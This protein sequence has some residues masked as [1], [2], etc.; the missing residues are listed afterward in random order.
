[1]VLGDKAG[2]TIFTKGNG[3]GACHGAYICTLL[4][5][6]Y[7]T[8]SHS[9]LAHGSKNPGKGTSQEIRSLPLKKQVF[10]EIK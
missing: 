8:H 9:P 1:M 2:L 5:I 10:K 4:C 6:L 3:P 7:G